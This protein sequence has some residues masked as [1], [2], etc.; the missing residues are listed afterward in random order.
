MYPLLLSMSSRWSFGRS[1]TPMDPDGRHKRPHRLQQRRRSHFAIATIAA[2][3]VLTTANNQREDRGERGGPQ[4]LLLLQPRKDLRQR[5]RALLN[6]R[7]ELASGLI[8]TAF[9]TGMR[10]GRQFG[11]SVASYRLCRLQTAMKVSPGPDHTGWP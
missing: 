7:G 6:G 1:F 11:S 3:A 2:V 4:Q 10:K 9:E 5:E 8:G